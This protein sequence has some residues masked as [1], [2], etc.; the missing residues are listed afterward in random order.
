MEIVFP[1][2]YFYTIYIFSYL[3]INQMLNLKIEYLS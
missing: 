2:I 3:F 1:D